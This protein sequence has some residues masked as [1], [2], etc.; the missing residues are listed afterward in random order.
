[1]IKGRL[2]DSGENIANILVNLKREDQRDENSIFAVH[3]LRPIIQNNCKMHNANIKIIE[4]PAGPPVQA[5]I[6]LEITNI[7]D[8]ILSSITLIYTLAKIAFYLI[9][10]FVINFF[11]GSK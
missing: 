4:S 2:F 9:I 10:L 1:M 3:R 7:L 6:V 11:I 5:S 8:I